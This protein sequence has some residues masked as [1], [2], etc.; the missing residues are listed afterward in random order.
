MMGLLLSTSLKF[1]MHK[2]VCTLTCIIWGLCIMGNI[3]E[4]LWVTEEPHS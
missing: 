3:G 2:L 1:H 4:A